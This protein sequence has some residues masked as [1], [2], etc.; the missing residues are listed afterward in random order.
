MIKTILSAVLLLALLQTSCNSQTNNDQPV[1]KNEEDEKKEMIKEYPD[2]FLLKQQLVE[3]YQKNGQLSQALSET[4]NMLKQ[5]TA[6]AALWN[7]KANLY[8]DNDDTLNAIY[9]LEKA[10]HFKAIPE[11]LKSLGSLY[12]ETKNPLALVI[13]DSLLN[14]PKSNSQEQALF[15]KGLY[16]SCIGNKQKAISFFD[17]CLSMDYND[18]FSYRE[19][20]MCLYDMN[21]YNDAL[22]VL[23]KATAIKSNYDEAYYWMG[24]CYE[25]LGDKD[26]AIEN[27]HTALGID[28]NYIEAKD[29]LA[30]L[31][32]Q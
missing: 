29:A 3:Y 31:N 22:A 6:N 13:A 23:Q 30:K 7:T 11:Y 19:K 8:F 24:R 32:S 4:E 17:V 20:A 12:A 25:K 10:T 2:S 9:S 15:I 27:Y 5:D 14:N 18:M 1:V 21:K 16:Y 26:E 28:K